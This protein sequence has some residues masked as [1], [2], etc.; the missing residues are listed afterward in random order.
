MG[1]E[2][3]LA[4]RMVAAHFGH[5]TGQIAVVAQAAD[6]AVQEA[7][8]AVERTGDPLGTQSW[9]DRAAEVNGRWRA[10]QGS[11]VDAQRALG[12]LDVA[13]LAESAL[14]EVKLASE[15][16][17]TAN[18]AL[19]GGAYDTALGALFSASEATRVAGEQQALHIRDLA[20]QHLF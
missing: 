2:R 6:K 11:V 19:D 16:L 3:Q 4:Q 9:V 14:P 15:M 5:N 18:A 10:S 1:I 12:E 17:R 20:E 13:S 8:V 7:V